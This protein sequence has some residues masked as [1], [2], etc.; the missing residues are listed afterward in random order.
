MRNNS[1]YQELIN[2]AR[3]NHLR[4][5]ES[6]Y[7]EIRDIYKD[8]S[9]EFDIKY[10]QAKRGSL[11]E[12]FA[13]DYMKVVNKQLKK[14]IIQ[15]FLSDKKFIKKAAEY[16][17]EIQL[18]FFNILGQKYGMDIDRTFRTVLSR[19]PEEAVAEIMNGLM[20]HDNKG[21][22]ER[23]WID[24]ELM[25]KDIGYM[26]QKAIVEKKS[27]E[28]FAKDIQVYVNPDARITWE[29]N[30]VY[31][32]V[33]KRKIEYNAQRLAR[34]SINHAFFLSNVRS[35]MKNPFVEAMHWELSASHMVRQV[36]PFGE[37][38]CDIYANHDEGLGKG[39]FPIDKIPLPHPQC[40]CSQWPVIPKSIEEIGNEIRKWLD[41]ESNSTLDSW[42]N[43]FG[44]EFAGLGKQNGTP[45]AFRK[46]ES[47]SN[48]LERQSRDIQISFLG[49]KKKWYLY[50]AGVLNE[51]DFSKPW[52]ELKNDRNSAIIVVQRTLTDGFKWKKG[53]LE[54]HVNKRK[55]KGHIP[56][57]WTEKDYQNR[58]MEIIQNKSSDVFLYYNKG[59]DQKYFVFG[60]KEWI[61]IIGENGIIDTAF[62]P[63]KGYDY[64][65]NE[66]LTGINY[67]STI[68]E[69]YKND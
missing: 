4:L 51:K 3:N 44:K 30:K 16:A 20:Y 28:E 53:K 14:M 69:L 58:I 1:E 60:D 49:G 55:K 18:S 54:K 64:Y 43:E 25:K 67:M 59:F 24:A 8:V 32:G 19:V 15:I 10:I 13:K 31:P 39:N 34:T 38:E 50:N 21:L 22:S 61:A 46:K 11:T 62:P 42:Y 7:K 36:I 5:Y 57:V 56:S 63:D 40:L 37:D 26:L 52:K 29:W 2:K 66:Q 35:S 45:Y 48:W 17:N 9:K 68:E 12:R 23:I 6:S 27:V 41:G 47:I 33:G 65:L